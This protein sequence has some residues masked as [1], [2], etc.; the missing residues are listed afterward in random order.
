MNF[1]LCLAL[2]TV[3]LAAQDQPALLEAISNRPDK[4]SGGNVL[5]RTA[6]GPLRLNG[7][8]IEPEIQD[9]KALITGLTV[10]RNKL[11]L[12]GGDGT[13]TAELTLN[14][15]PISGP[16]FSGPQEQ[17]FLCQT[18]K[19]PL[20]G[21]AFL[22]PP[23]DS[24]CSVE[25]VV[26]YVYKA[27]DKSWKPLISRTELPSDIANTTTSLGRTVPYIVRLETGVINRS[28]YQVAVLHNPLAEL[29]PTPFLPPRAWNQ[30]VLYS[31]GGGCIGG[32]YKQGSRL[33][34]PAGPSGVGLASD[35]VVA[36]GYASVSAS[37]NVFGNN[38]NDVLAAETMMMVKEHFIENY[39]VPL[40]T[41]GR[42]GSGG[43][44]QQI[45]IADNYP[46]LLDGIIPGS[47]FPD[48]LA[49]IQFLTDIQ[50]LKEYFTRT[51]DALTEQQQRAIAGVGNFRTIVSTAGGAE[52][53]KGAGNCPPELPEALRYD[54]LNN[55]TG[56]RCNVFDHTVNVYGRDP[57]TGFALRPLDN[58]G[59]QYGLAALNAG[60]IN[61]SQFL[62][63]NQGVGGHDQDGN[64]VPWR[65]RADLKAIRAAYETGRVTNGGAGLATVPIIDN[66]QY[67]D[68]RTNGDLHLKYHSFGFRARLQRAN[69]SSAN[70][71]M[72][73]TAD[74][75]PAGFEMYTIAMMDEW[76][77]N[78][79][80]DTSPDPLREKVIRAKP[81][82]LRDACYSSTGERIVE[83]QT[84][85][86]GQ[87][88][89]LYPTFPSPRMV[90]GGP[91]TNDVLKCQLKPIDMRDYS[92]PFTPEERARLAAV[93]P[94]GVCDYI[95]PGIGRVP[96]RGTWL[97][98]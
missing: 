38:C 10:G 42:G 63:L 67:L 50:L 8:V 51:G 24:N 34:G 80:A 1:R 86:D 33:G 57:Q 36:L 40:F 52:R 7:E 54:P 96:L 17:P 89:E 15:H 26:S 37:L 85:S 97:S 14:N 46:G 74:R 6:P 29:V 83:P 28:I 73:V 94:D 98:Y 62:D 53:I 19:F 25:T 95:K 79:K 68:M 41:F 91:V 71:V 44:Y 90:A 39:G 92:V 81:A 12:L 27:T 72:L 87:C 20:P 70:E 31:F 9:G 82:D 48:V 4:I 21:D 66:R 13:K 56:A 11:E 35:A 3:A 43:A 45:Q 16:V 60:V 77:T 55:R 5:V 64:I 75:A 59:V 22:G 30:R 61:P 18:D 47:T 93:F 32:W 84:F 76:L 69:G 88:N 65:S 23:L 2:A 49:T 58:T 78:L